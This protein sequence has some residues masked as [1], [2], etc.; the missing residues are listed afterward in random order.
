M[1]FLLNPHRF[2]PP[3]WEFVNSSTFGTSTSGNISASA[4]PP[5]PIGELL[6]CNIFFRG[7]VGFTWPAAWTMVYQDTTGNTANNQQVGVQ[8]GYIIRTEA[9]I[10]TG[11]YTPVFTRT[12]GNHTV[13]SIAVVRSRRGIPSFNNYSQLENLTQ[14]T[15]YSCPALDIVTN[16]SLVFCSVGVAINYVLPIDRGGFY[17]ENMP[18]AAPTPNTDAFTYR[19]NT[20]LNY[21][22]NGWSAG[23]INISGW[24]HMYLDGARIGTT[25]TFQGTGL[26]NSS[27][28]AVAAS[29]N[30]L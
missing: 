10:G 27:H 30:P 20:W 7:S 11:S 23:A 16:E 5:G 13:A 28:Y 14:T 15:S 19:R 1:T 12:G 25:G 22:Y 8:S 6:Y 2:T 26:E 4:I 18:Y 3:A 17:A 21:W 24:G 29:F 9:N